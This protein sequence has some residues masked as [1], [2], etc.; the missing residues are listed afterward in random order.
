[1]L[2]HR[3]FDKVNKD[4]LHDTKGSEEVSELTQAC[5]KGS[6]RT[7]EEALRVFTGMTSAFVGV[8]SPNSHTLYVLSTASYRVRCRTMCRCSCPLDPTLP[9]WSRTDTSVH[10]RLK[11][12]RHEFHSRSWSSFHDHTASSGSHVASLFCCN[13]LAHLYKPSIQLHL[14]QPPRRRNSHLSRQNLRSWFEWTPGLTSC[15]TSRSKR[16]QPRPLRA[17]ATCFHLLLLL[18]TCWEAC[19]DLL[20]ELRCCCCCCGGGGGGRTRTKN[21]PRPD[22]TTPSCCCCCWHLCHWVELCPVTS[23]VLEHCPGDRSGW[24]GKL[25]RQKGAAKE[26]PGQEKDAKLSPRSCKRPESEFCTALE[27]SCK[28]KCGQNCAYACGWC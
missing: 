21:L 28:G 8:C 26:S 14:D 12:A 22:E 10:A 1:M 11:I 19:T 6:P 7:L 16:W 5:N 27:W 17:R 15:K 13:Y 9:W 20:V 25:G 24:G 3:A 2:G 18:R 4:A 23:K